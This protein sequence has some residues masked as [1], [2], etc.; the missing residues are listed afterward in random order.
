MQYVWGHSWKFQHFLVSTSNFKNDFL[1]ACVRM[2]PF[3]FGNIKLLLHKVPI[4]VTFKSKVG[5]QFT[6]LSYL[7]FYFIHSLSSSEITGFES[8]FLRHFYKAFGVQQ[9][10]N[11]RWLCLHWKF[12][13]LLNEYV[14]GYRHFFRILR[15]FN[16]WINIVNWSQISNISVKY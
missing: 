8:L 14:L 13:Y 15:Q 3:D 5:C 16:T 4:S 6:T 9:F 1:K 2:N 10:L 7:L 12:Y 11:S